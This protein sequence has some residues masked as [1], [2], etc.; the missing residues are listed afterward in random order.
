VT[1]EAKKLSQQYDVKVPT[2]Y[3]LHATK[4]RGN[5]H[6]LPV[7]VHLNF[8]V[9]WNARS[10]ANACSYALCSKNACRITG[11]VLW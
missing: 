10:I 11:S 1:S 6:S 2:Q 5:C 8:T 7:V 9:F 4:T 3:K